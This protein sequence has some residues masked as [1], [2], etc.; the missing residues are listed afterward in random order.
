MYNRECIFKSNFEGGF[1]F[2]FIICN[3]S[4]VLPSIMYVIIFNMYRLLAIYLIIFKWMKYF[5]F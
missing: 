1:T 2:I 5:V 3:T 4:F